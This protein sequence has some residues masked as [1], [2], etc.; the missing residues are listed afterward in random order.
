LTRGGVLVACACV[1][2]DDPLLVE[3]IGVSLRGEDAVRKQPATRSLMNRLRCRCLF[4]ILIFPEIAIAC[5]L[6]T[7]QAQMER[8]GMVEMRTKSSLMRC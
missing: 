7:W 4:S 8:K 3:A 2:Q 6:L 5:K 1:R